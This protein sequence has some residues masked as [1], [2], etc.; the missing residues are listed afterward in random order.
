LQLGEDSEKKKAKKVALSFGPKHA[1]ISTQIDLNNI[2]PELA[3][4][5]ICFPLFIGESKGEKITA[6]VGRFGPYL[7]KI[8]EF[9]SIPK[10]KD[11]LTITLAEAEEIFATEKKGRG[12]KKT[13]L[14]ELGNDPDTSKP[15]Q[16]I[17]GPYGPYI[18]NGS[19]V[20]A[21]VPKETKPE[22]VTLEQALQMIKEKQGSKKKKR[23]KAS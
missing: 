10:D 8:D 18:S 9:R 14:K 20:F 17:D 15:V 5:I 1:P 12:R 22:D 19:K 2:T 21:P 13:I 4:R 7:K 11:I 6:S 3:Q 16:I 23:T